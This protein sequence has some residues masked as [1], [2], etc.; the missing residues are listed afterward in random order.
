MWLAHDLQALAQK[1][2]EAEQLKMEQLFTQFADHSIR[3]SWEAGHT[4]YFL[5]VRLKKNNDHQ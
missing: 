4:L 3:K 1:Q 2:A 5:S